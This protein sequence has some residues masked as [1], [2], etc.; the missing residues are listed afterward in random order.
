MALIDELKIVCD[1][2][3]PLGW[4]TLLKKV[5]GG[6]LNISQST[7][8]K[9]KT[10][11]TTNLASVDRAIPGFED[12]NPA[13]N[14][15]A[16][17]GKPSESLLYHALASPLVTRDNEGRALQGFASPA[18]LDVLENFIFSLISVSLPQ[19]IQQQGGAS[20]VAAVVFA[21]EYR[22]AD[23]TVDGRHADLTFSRTGIGR[24][25][26]ARP[27]YNAAARGFWSEDE[28][29]VHNIR[30]VPARFA[31]RIAPRPQVSPSE[32]TEPTKAAPSFASCF[33]RAPNYNLK[34][35]LRNHLKKAK[36]YV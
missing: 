12:F 19:F 22:P 7:A 10:A 36:T 35:K 11:L 14:R 32:R 8:T 1:R 20:K 25:G 6:A 34:L 4:A 2:L 23:H 13:G 16:V 18:E 24:V 15:G 26:T 28:D 17:A 5:T 21:S 30:V 29:N 9:L 31:S 33:Y 27:L 3:A